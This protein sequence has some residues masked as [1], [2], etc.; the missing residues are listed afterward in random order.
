[1]RSQKQMSEPTKSASSPKRAVLSCSKRRFTGITSTP[2]SA[3][4]SSKKGNTLPSASTAVTLAPNA[5]A[6]KTPAAPHPQPI[7]MTRAPFRGGRSR[8]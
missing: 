5:F 6:Q 4:M 1:M 2:F 3:A 7:S 8:R